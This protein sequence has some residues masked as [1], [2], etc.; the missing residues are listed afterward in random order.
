MPQRV[1][2]QYLAR[3]AAGRFRPAGV[4][5]PPG[6]RL[7]AALLTALLLAVPAVSAAP[8]AKS[9]YAKTG[10]ATCHG[11]D[12]RTPR[13]DTTPNIAGQPPR[14]LYLVMR[15]YKTGERQGVGSSQHAEVSDL[16]DD[17]QMKAL[18]EYVAGL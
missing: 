15:A 8:D 5:T 13:T 6:W 1:N 17:E 7:A 2:P 10:C 16:L 11:A 4:A 14:Y 18:A 3:R 12:G 9:L